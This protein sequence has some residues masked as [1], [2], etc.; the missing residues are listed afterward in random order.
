MPQRMAAQRIGRQEE[1]V[2]DQ[3][4]R[5][6]PQPEMLHA[7]GIGKPQSFPGVIR[8]DENEYHRDIHKV[9]MHILDNQRE[10]TFAKVFFARLADRAVDGVR[11]ER[12][13]IGA[14]IIVTR[15][16][17]TARGPQNQQGGG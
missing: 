3:N 17:K 12:L 16:T 13:V 14:A 5:T 8:Q 15:K 7:M 10:I 2:Q 4:N 6:N 1:Y 11:P 9:A